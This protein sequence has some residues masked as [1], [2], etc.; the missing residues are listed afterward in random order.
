V[1]SRWIDIKAQDGN[2]FKGYLSLHRSSARSRAPDS[3]PGNDDQ[4]MDLRK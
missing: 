1:N 2:R 3:I 4:L